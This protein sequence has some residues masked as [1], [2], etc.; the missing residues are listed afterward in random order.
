MNQNSLVFRTLEV[1]GTRVHH[2]GQ[3]L[4][5]EKLRGLFGVNVDTDLE[6][7]RGGLRWVLNPAD[8]MQSGLFWLDEQDRWELYHIRKM[9]EPGALIFDVGANFGYYSIMLASALGGRCQVHAFE[10]NEKTCLRLERNI[11]LNSLGKSVFAHRVGL[12]D[13]QGQGKMVE[14]AD[15]SGAAWIEMNGEGD[16]DL[17]TLDAFCDERSIDRLDFIKVDIEGFEERMLL[18]GSQTLQRHQP[19]LLVE[20][21]PSTLVRQNSS[22]ERIAEL[23]RSLGYALYEAQREKLAPLE[24]LPQGEEFINAFCLPSVSSRTV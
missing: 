15:N 8:H 19:P 1:Y 17:T 12:S 16:A 4:V 14:R 13:T 22:A 3:W 5:H 10:P 20:L 23:L 24:R 6:V 21:N 11:E 2:R 9:L 7:E 18:G